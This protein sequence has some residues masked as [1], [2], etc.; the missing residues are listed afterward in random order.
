LGEGRSETS[1]V[2]EHDYVRR[3]DVDQVL[4]VAGFDR[5][6][7]CLY[8]GPA[9]GPGDGRAR[10]ARGDVRAGPVGELAYCGRALA[11][12]LG[13][14]DVLLLAERLPLLR[15]LAELTIPMRRDELITCH[16]DIKPA[17]TVRTPDGELRLIDWDDVSPAS[18]D[19]ELA[20]VVQGWCDG[21]GDAL[22]TARARE[23][24]TAY[25]A[26]GGPGR[27]RPDSFGYGYSLNATHA[28]LGNV[29]NPQVT[30]T[31]RAT[32]RVNA[33]R[34]L[35]TLPSHA[36]AEVLLALDRSI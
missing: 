22:H 30:P 11:D 33:F 34:A 8:G 21:Y 9:V 23:L 1:A 20:E 28:V 32:A 29:A 18:A 5:L 17:N 13:D 12:G 24:L 4:Q 15:E 36:P 26:A 10:A 19:R 7:E 6:L 27:L 31:V 2:G 3:E 16:L 25:R 14:L 35:N